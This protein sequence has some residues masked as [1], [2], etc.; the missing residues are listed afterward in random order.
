MGAP[1]AALDRAY[2]ALDPNLRPNAQSAQGSQANLDRPGTPSAVVGLSV[3]PRRQ[4]CPNGVYPNAELMGRIYFTDDALRRMKSRPIVSPLPHV[5]EPYRVASTTHYRLREN[6]QPPLQPQDAVLATPPQKTP[7][8]LPQVR[9]RRLNRPYGANTPSLHI[10]FSHKL[11]STLR[12]VKCRTITVRFNYGLSCEV[13]FLVRHLFDFLH[14]A[15]RASCSEQ[16]HFSP[17]LGS[18]RVRE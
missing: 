5:P 13:D 6:R 10:A 18:M 3:R 9:K 4:P 16:S 8:S 14:P 1:R 12:R 11:V 15:R 17:L 2:P 7:R